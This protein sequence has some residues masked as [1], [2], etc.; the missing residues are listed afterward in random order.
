MPWGVSHTKY[1]GERGTLWYVPVPTATVNGSSRTISTHLYHY[2]R[3]VNMLPRW[4]I[5]VKATPFRMKFYNSVNCSIRVKKSRNGQR[6][7][8][9]GTEQRYQQSANNVI[10]GMAKWG[11]A[12]RCPNTV[13]RHNA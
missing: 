6:E 7:Y 9:P 4:H 8:P 2:S 3:Q 11:S 12:A 1:H 13:G 10:T 5:I